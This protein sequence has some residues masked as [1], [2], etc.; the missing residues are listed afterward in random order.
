MSKK[1]FVVIEKTF[2]NNRLYD[3]EVDTGTVDIDLR[4]GDGKAV[5]WTRETYPALRPADEDEK[6]PKVEGDLA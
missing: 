2:I 4:D 6:K 5:T 1:K 3:P